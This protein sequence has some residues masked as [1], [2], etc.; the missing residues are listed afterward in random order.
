[1]LLPLPMNSAIS[2]PRSASRANAPLRALGLSSASRAEVPGAQWASVPPCPHPTPQIPAAFMVL[3]YCGGSSLGVVQEGVGSWH[4]DWRRQAVVSGQH[5]SHI[6]RHC[7]QACQ[8]RTEWQRSWAPGSLRR[9]PPPGHTRPAS[10][11]ARPLGACRWGGFSPAFSA[12]CYFGAT[13]GH[14][15]SPR[16]RKGLSAAAQLAL[17]EGSGGKRLGGENG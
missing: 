14:R 4:R 3:C 9:V 10:S 8:P 5:A 6:R 11:P 1:M 17:E 13:L 16:C 12:S 2:L 7:H 15:P